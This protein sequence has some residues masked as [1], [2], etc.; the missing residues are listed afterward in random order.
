MFPILSPRSLW[1]WGDF[2]L[3]LSPMTLVVLRSMGHIYSIPVRLL[4][5]MLVLMTGLGYGFY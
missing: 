1:V 2:Y 4:C 5:L 3:F